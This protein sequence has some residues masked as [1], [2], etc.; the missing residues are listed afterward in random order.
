MCQNGGT[1]RLHI[2][3]YLCECIPEFDGSFCE[4]KYTNKTWHDTYIT[5]AAV[6]FTLTA[7]FVLYIIYIPLHSLLI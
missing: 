5:I 4:S 7:H 2:F 3:E 6:L 1:C